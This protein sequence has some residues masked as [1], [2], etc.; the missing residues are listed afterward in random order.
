MRDEAGRSLRF[1]AGEKGVRVRE[2]RA[3][4]RYSVRPRV[5]GPGDRPE[6]SEKGDA[7]LL[8]LGTACEYALMSGNYDAASLLD[9]R[10]RDALA[11][12]CRER[13]GRLRMRRWV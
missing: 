2:G 10:Y 3:V 7:R 12:A 11:C 4:I 5:K 9:R 1:A 6:L 13:G 8:A